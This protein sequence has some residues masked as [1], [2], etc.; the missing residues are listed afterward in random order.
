MTIFGFARMTAMVI[1]AA[2]TL[3]ACGDDDMQA[4]DWSSRAEGVMC[5]MKWERP[6]EDRSLVIWW[7]GH[8]RL[9]IELGREGWPVLRDQDERI[10]NTVVNIAPNYE[11][12]GSS[13]K[14]IRARILGIDNHD[15]FLTA[16]E[17]EEAPMSIEFPDERWSVGL[18]GAA[19]VAKHFRE[20]IA[21][22]TPP[23]W[24]RTQ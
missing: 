23:S 14:G 19:K 11:L 21:A 9:L 3:A 20:C 22:T 12:R 7:T 5:R 17:R 4:G 1:A 10:P 16:F 13:R 24:R 18:N 8:S 2:I 15:A 6:T